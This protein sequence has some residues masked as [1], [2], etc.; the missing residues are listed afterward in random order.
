M[1]RAVDVNKSVQMLTAPY[2]DDDF[3]GFFEVFTDA[4]TDA[5]SLI[6]K[7]CGINEMMRSERDV[8]CG[9]SIEESVHARKHSLNLGRR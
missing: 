4:D 7:K 5:V 9:K 6:E 8:S 1:R 3:G 2:V